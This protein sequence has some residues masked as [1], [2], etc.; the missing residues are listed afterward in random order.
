[1]RPDPRVIR[2]AP[3]NPL[4]VTGRDW[5]GPTVAPDDFDGGWDNRV[6]LVDG[7]WVDRTPRFPDREPQLRREAALLPW[8]RPLLPLPIPASRVV[9]EDP[10]TLRHA[11]LPGVRCPGTSPVH[12]AEIGRFLRA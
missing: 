10:F 12:G 6:T 7:R 8:L 1:P 9:S 11:Y 5:W 3:R 2:A 4:A